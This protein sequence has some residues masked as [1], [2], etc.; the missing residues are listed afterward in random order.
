MLKRFASLFSRSSAAFS[1]SGS[2]LG[3]MERSGG[4]RSGMPAGG[5]YSVAEARLAHASA[6]VDSRYCFMLR[7]KTMNKIDTLS[8]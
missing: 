5:Q 1:G 2:N 3:A 8:M 6:V 4:G 7:L